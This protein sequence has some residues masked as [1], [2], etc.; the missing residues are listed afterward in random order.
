MGAPPFTL[1]ET[2]CVRLPVCNFRSRTGLSPQPYFDE[3]DPIG[4]CLAPSAATRARCSQP[5]AE[6][7]KV[8]ISSGLGTT[9][10]EMKRI[11]SSS[12]LPRA[13]AGRDPRRDQKVHKSQRE[14]VV[15]CAKFGTLQLGRAPSG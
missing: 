9:V 11:S 4:E 8:G 2:P 14:H 5:R 13:W 6:S 7:A 12:C 3:P 1:L 10:P 15:A